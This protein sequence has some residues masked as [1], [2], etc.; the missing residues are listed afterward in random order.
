MV[1]AYKVRTQIAKSLQVRSKAIRRAIKTYNAAAAKLTPPRAPLDWS[2]VSH[3]TFIEE[4]ELLRDTR[5]DLSDKKWAQSSTREH[6][7]RARRIRS[8]QDEIARCN[9]EVRRLHTA[10]L[11]E[12]AELDAAVQSSRD[13]RNPIAGAIAEHS[14]RRQAVNA[15]LLAVIGRIHALR[16]FT[17]DRTPGRR[18]GTTSDTP[19]PHSP[20]DNSAVQAE[21]RELGDDDQEDLD[22]DRQ[23]E[24][25]RVMDFALSLK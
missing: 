14:Q 8:A 24:A 15:R 18:K 11:L 23:V 5:N 25:T 21:L 12:N 7:K 20:T 22:D 2:K 4:F 19:A 6:L 1:E 13:E 3:Y 10:I 9:L 17:G 16:G